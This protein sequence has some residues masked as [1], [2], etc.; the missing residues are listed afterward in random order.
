MTINFLKIIANP[1]ALLSTAYNCSIVGLTLLSI[2]CSTP[3]TAQT[4][5]NLLDTSNQLD[6]AAASVSDLPETTP[7]SETPNSSTY[8]TNQ[9]PSSPNLA[10]EPEPAK[11]QSTNTPNAL[12]QPSAPSTDPDYIIPPPIAPSV[13]NLP[14]ASPLSE[15]PNWSTYATDLE[16]SSPNLASEPEPAKP[17]STNTPNG[18]PQPSAP[19][20]DPDYIIPPRI[21]PDEKI[22]PFTTNLPLNDIPISHLTEWEFSG[23]KTFADTTNSDIFLNG[24]LKLKSRVTESL[25]RTNIYRVDQKATYLQLRT[26]PLE[27]KITTTTTAPQTMTGLEIQMSLTAACLFPNTSS[28]QQCTYTPG[29]AIDRN[30][31]DPEFFVPT[32]VFQTS[33]VGE[34]VKPETLAFMQLPGFQG[35]TSSQPI[36]VDFYF[37][38]SGA[39]PGNSQS[40]KTKVDRKE[41]VDYTIAGTVSRVRQ[42][43]KAN[44]REAVLGRTIRGFTLFID[45]ENR[46]LNTAIQ[47]GAQFLPDVIPD[48]E[49]SKNPVNT[50]INRNLFLAANNTRLPSSSFTIY[51][52]G[53]GRAESLTPNVTSINQVPKANY[54]SLWLGL[55]PVIDRNIE[56]GRIFYAPTG[57]QITLVDA[58]AEG[59]ADTNVQ[60][61]SA[62]NQ[63][64]YSTANLQ[65]FYAQVYLGFLQ[66][67][68]N[69]VRESI[70]REKSS[71]YPH[72][73]FTGN[74]TGGE[75]I[76]RYYTGVIAS[77]K[78]KLYLGA[79]YTRNTLNNWSFR[80]GAIGYLNPDRDYYSQ[81]WGSAAKTFRFSRRANLTLSTG[82]NY[83]LD[84]ETRIGD[85]VS[86]SPASEV[87]LSARVNWGIVSLG[88][89][90]YFG[91]ILPNSYDERLLAELTIRPLSTLTLSGYIAPIDKNSTRSLY[92][93]SVSWQ[94]ENNYNSPTLSLNWQNNQY[95]YGDD[96]FGNRLLLND[97]IFTI[98]F[99]I[100]SPANPLSR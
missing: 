55:S 53:L 36:G 42:V 38:N 88:L 46:W 41:E 63:N 78:P 10:P 22:S 34:V 28:D 97:N 54:N 1:T 5:S 56:D 58:G 52:A 43:V 94:L 39:Y 21:A 95:D 92:G 83:A 75:D 65:N 74:W 12:P 24:T 61:L 6:S 27:R 76:L 96:V 99:R 48:L 100:G 7:L 35:G 20:T 49:G 32:R 60:S 66:Q 80:G 14:E 73:S 47:A 62:V 59:G 37:P 23:F 16:P 72:L 71:Y 89:T 87:V 29:L 67:D 3:A 57:P 51:S 91:N 79:D 13:S 70:Y 93:A 98:L 81:I 4:R 82:F 84:R 30:S 18:L 17:P 86:I 19:S 26:V 8:P 44:D 9:E 69:F 85:L 90:N 64:Q 40:R 33:Q 77:E 45:D 15:T 25:S 2:A 31:I 68:V 11:P 50:N